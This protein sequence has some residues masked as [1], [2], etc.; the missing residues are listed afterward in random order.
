MSY[1]LQCGGLTIFPQLQV[2]WKLFLKIE[3]AHV[4]HPLTNLQR[5]VHYSNHWYNY[6]SICK[7]VMNDFVIIQYRQLMTIVLEHQSILNVL[8]VVLFVS[9]IVLLTNFIYCI[10]CN[11]YFCYLCSCLH[12]LDGEINCFIF[13]IFD[14]PMGLLVD[15]VVHYKFDSPMGP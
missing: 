4:F 10:S 9:L 12:A 6:L 5:V 7:C 11:L 2:L 3:N 1:I 14:T 15:Q 13:Y 8:L